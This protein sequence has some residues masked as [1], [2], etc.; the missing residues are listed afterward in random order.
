LF[1]LSAFAREI[2]QNILQNKEIRLIF[3]RLINHIHGYS[4]YMIT[5]IKKSIKESLPKYPGVSGKERFFNSAVLV[6]LILIGEEP[7][8][9]LEKRAK[10]I[11]QEGEICFPG[12]GFDEQQD[13][14]LQ[15]TALRE[16]KEELGIPEDNIDILGRLN[17]V[18]AAMGVSIDPFAGLV[19]NI[20][21]DLF[22]IEKNEV[23]KLLVIPVSWF[24]VNQPETYHVTLEV[25]PYYY[26]KNGEK[27]ETLPVKDLGLPDRYANPWGCK[28][29][30]V[31]FYQYQGEKIWGLTAEIIDD[32]ISCCFPFT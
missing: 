6:P 5:E 21:V 26:N 4:S 9:I 18:I 14:S 30:R 17:T 10:G 22:S 27:V 31:L 25:K 23:E 3:I 1:I 24:Q 16:T 12:G 13:S 15:D 28:K 8:F 11:A 2:C 29:Y 20:D 19:E 7:C 32:F